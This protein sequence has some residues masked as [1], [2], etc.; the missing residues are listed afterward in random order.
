MVI[1]YPKL[2]K[3][4]AGYGLGLGNFIGVVHG[5]MV[6]A[7]GVDIYLVAERF[8]RNHAALQVPPREAPRATHCTA[9][10]TGRASHSRGAFG[11]LPRCILRCSF[12]VLCVRLTPLLRCALHRIRMRGS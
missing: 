7:A 5:N 10:L 1:V 2:A 8:A 9:L 11:T 6:D 12:S 3:W 4:L